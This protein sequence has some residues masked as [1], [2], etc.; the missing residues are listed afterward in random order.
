MNC[1]QT[2]LARKKKAAALKASNNSQALA[3]ASPYSNQSV[4]MKQSSSLNSHS[5]NHQNSLPLSSSATIPPTIGPTFPATSPSIPVHSFTPKRSSSS[6]K[7]KSLPSLPTDDA[8]PGSFPLSQSY[9]AHTSSTQLNRSNSYNTP[10]SN[11]SDSPTN[12]FGQNSFSPPIRPVNQPAFDPALARIPQRSLPLSSNSRS[13]SS[14]S[15]HAQNSL[16]STVS[17]ST[18][19]S[20]PASQTSNGNSLV[21]A[22][23]TSL[24]SPVASSISPYPSNVIDSQTFNPSTSASL[25]ETKFENSVDSYSTT[26]HSLN[27][28][29]TNLNVSSKSTE[30][31]PSTHILDKAHH[32]QSSTDFRDITS[33]NSSSSSPTNDIRRNELVPS[34]PLDSLRNRSPSARG[35]VYVDSTLNSPSGEISL[36]ESFINE[37]KNKDTATRTSKISASTDISDNLVLKHSTSSRNASPN[38]H[39][40][41]NISSAHQTSDPNDLHSGNSYDENTDPSHYRSIGDTHIP[42]PNSAK[43]DGSAAVM[44]VDAASNTSSAT[45]GSYPSVDSSL[46]TIREL[47]NAKARIAE[48]EQQLSQRENNRNMDSNI[49]EKRKTIAGLEAKGTVAK[50]ELQLLADAISRKDNLMHSKH[51]LVSAFTTD[52]S[53]FKRSLQAEIESLILER[54]KLTEERDRLVSTT[55]NLVKE[56]NS[57]EERKIQVTCQVNQLHDMHI[58]LAKQAMQKFGPMMNKPLHPNGKDDYTYEEAT[59]HVIDVSTDDKKERVHGRRFWKRPTA[60]MAKGVKGFN[61]KFAQDQSQQFVTTG[62]YVDSSPFNNDE[63]CTSAN[64]GENATE[65]STLVSV[66]LGGN[67]G[68]KLRN[69]WFNKSSSNDAVPA[70]SSDTPSLMGYDIEQRVSYERTSI[71]LIVTRCIQEVEERGMTY[72]GVYRKSG[73]RSQV[74]SI[75]EAFE[76]HSNDDD[77]RSLDEILS[78]DI[79]GVTSALKQY[80]RHLPNPLITFEAYDDFVEASRQIHSNTDAA[81]EQ[82]RSVINTLPQVYKECLSMVCLHLKNISSQSD[83]NLMTTKNLAVVFAPTLVRHTN[84]ERE[85]M[86]MGPRNDGTQ[87]L[88][89]KCDRVFADVVISSQSQ[90]QSQSSPSNSQQV[91]NVK[92]KASTNGLREDNNSNTHNPQTL[93]APGLSSATKS[94]LH[95][96]PSRKL[97]SSNTKSKNTMNKSHNGNP[98]FSHTNN[99]S[100]LNIGIQH[101]LPNHHSLSTSNDTDIPTL[102]VPAASAIANMGAAPASQVGITNPI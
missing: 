96:S 72:E 8:S 24:S 35:G 73:G 94:N 66:G 38:F 20:T 2:L 97:S 58:E 93:K 86:D 48:L 78:G 57:L 10:S 92:R 3:M 61:K 88:I 4:S 64:D 37:L 31:S 6:F 102:Q 53:E 41:K 98:S 74:S 62:P 54:D 43:Y 87:L 5:L 69:G 47:Y 44:L 33:S 68:A 29:N 84:G 45:A 99:L 59:P 90:S 22:V 27:P 76:K 56:C 1:H 85:I 95:R 83:I 40:A 11:K 46:P 70:N 21:P 55:N 100:E 28:N 80:L 15:D 89:E 14:S 101:R 25:S 30:I 71:P 26:S 18:T 51:E 12:G 65:T 82:V 17:K 16:S 81:V 13:T 79:A 42:Y 32:P 23:S 75:E 67:N 52:L 50:R 19:A 7:E 39:N 60:A 91:Q 36:E 9:L 63:E 34:V 77:P 49:N